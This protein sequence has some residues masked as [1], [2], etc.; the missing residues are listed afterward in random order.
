MVL[1]FK[2]DVY[3]EKALK[4]QLSEQDI[5][6]SKDALLLLIKDV[7]YEDLSNLCEIIKDY[8]ASLANPIDLSLED[9]YKLTQSDK[10]NDIE[11]TTITNLISRGIK[12]K[13]Y[14]GSKTI[15]NGQINTSSWI[16]HSFYVGEVCS[17]LA[18]KLGLD[19]D[20]ARTMG[21][22]HDY[23]RKF[24]HSFRHIIDGFEALTDL[25][26]NNEAIG[27]LTHSF[28]N[29]G[30]CSNNERAVNGFYLD[31]D[32][33]ANW[34]KDIVKDDITL[35]LENYKFTD[36]DLLLNIADLMATDKG[37]V[38]PKK[39]I[40]DVATRRIIDPI[41]RGYFLADITNVFI[42]IL[43]RFNLVSDYITHIK[44]DELTSLHQINEYF[45]IVSDCFYI[46]FSKTYKNKKSNIK[47]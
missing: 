21:L 38:S 19:E 16:S 11:K 8:Y 1:N 2:N 36:Y 26:W 3:K 25:G 20:K 18:N 6:S 30:R 29:G 32:G 15:N 24:N 23:G 10:L 42:E 28:V 35:F 9:C 13:K 7:S 12:E 39:R 17:I 31:K 45:E 27:C 14:L 43:K 22:L 4:A 33:N 34:K 40:A 41:N 5:H 47:R 44:H 37:I 46:A